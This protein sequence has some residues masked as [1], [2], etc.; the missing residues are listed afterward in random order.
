[1][2]LRYCV[3]SASLTAPGAVGLESPSHLRGH[4]EVKFQRV[5]RVQK[6]LVLVGNALASRLQGSNGQ[7]QQRQLRGDSSISALLQG[8]D[9]S[10]GRSPEFNVPLKVVNPYAAI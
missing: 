1:M 10:M 3:A 4:I 5:S 6:Q 9:H 8:L 7:F 2:M